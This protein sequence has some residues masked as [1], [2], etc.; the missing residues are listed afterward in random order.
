MAVCANCEHGVKDHD[1]DGCK[2]GRAF[3][4]QDGHC[5]CPFE[6][7][8][9]TG[10]F[11]A[12]GYPVVAD[13]CRTCGHTRN[14]HSYSDDPVCS[15]CTVCDGYTHPTGGWVPECGLGHSHPTAAAW[16]CRRKAGHDHYH[17]EGLNRWIHGVV[18]SEQKEEDVSTANPDRVK[19]ADIQVGGEH[20]R[21]TGIQPWDIIDAWGLD[22][23]AGNAL[24]YL[25]RA[26]R[27]GPKVEDLKKARHYIDKMIEK[28]ES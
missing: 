13:D 24:K 14:W 28:E 20:Y 8:S 23:Y 19:V 5:N 6:Y 12:K 25:Y 11:S 18:I 22:F 21:Q 10:D 17:A 1:A 2:Y 27:K 3:K 16:R 26:G 9:A 15:Q 4:D 7:D